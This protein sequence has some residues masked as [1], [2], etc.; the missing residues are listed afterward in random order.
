MIAYNPFNNTDGPKFV[1]ADLYLYKFTQLEKNSTNWW[2]RKFVKSYVPPIG[3]YHLKDYLNDLEW[4]I[5]I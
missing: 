1:K 2:V 3:I 5:S 4:N